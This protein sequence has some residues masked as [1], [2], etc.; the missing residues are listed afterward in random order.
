ML[1]IKHVSL[2]CV[3]VAINLFMFLAVV[4]YAS[5]ISTPSWWYELLGE[6]AFSVITWM[7][8]THS[9][10][11]LAGVIPVALILVLVYPQTKYTIAMI[12][13]ATLAVYISY[14]AVRGIVQFGLQDS[15]GL[16]ISHLLDFIKVFAIMLLAVFVLN[17]AVHPYKLRN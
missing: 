2:F 8:I 4:P 12:V 15:L 11:V 9:L 17:L 10:S 3:M 16:L 14:Y 5:A 6:N 7:Q 1:Y 13:A